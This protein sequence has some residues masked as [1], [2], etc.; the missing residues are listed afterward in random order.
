M[1]VKLFSKALFARTGTALAAA[2]IV[3]L[4]LMPVAAPAQTV[5]VPT[6]DNPFGLPED[7]TLFRTADPDR[8][9]ATAIVNGFVI[10]GTDID[11]RVALV[12]AASDAPVPEEEMLRLRVQ[13]LRNLI[14]ETLKIQ[15]AAA[16]EME[17]KREEVEQTTG[18]A[19]IDQTTVIGGRTV[20][21]ALPIV[22]GSSVIAS[23]WLQCITIIVCCV[24]SSHMYSRALHIFS[25]PC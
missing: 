15:A 25:L 3:G 7:I 24:L 12:T 14:D 16:A 13:V 11:K 6:A 2:G 23:P 20:S 18:L 9:T 1:S 19:M 22:D 5:A 17:V 10:T 4:A 21:P 8:R